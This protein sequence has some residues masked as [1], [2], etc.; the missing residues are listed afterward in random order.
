MPRTAATPTVPYASQKKYRA[1]NP[2]KVKAINQRY[3]QKNKL[4]L[5]AERRTRYHSVEK[6]R[7]AREQ[8][9]EQIVEIIREELEELEES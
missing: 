5:Q 9:M 7:K 1:N 4:K 2:E 6:P 3:Y 8:I